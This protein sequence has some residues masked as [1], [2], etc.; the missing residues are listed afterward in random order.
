VGPAP[1]AAS[2]VRA[3]GCAAAPQGLHPGSAASPKPG[4]CRNAAG[5]WPGPAG[6]QLLLGPRSGLGPGGSGAV[7]RSRAMW[8]A[9]GPGACRWPTN[10]MRRQ[11]STGVR[12][13]SRNT[14][15]SCAPPRT[16][17]GLDP[18]HACLRHT[19][20]SC[21][22]GRAIQQSWTRAGAWLACMMER[23][24]RARCIPTQ[25][26]QQALGPGSAC[27]LHRPVP[28]A[29]RTEPG[30]A[31]R[32]CRRTSPS[33]SNAWIG[34]TACAKRASAGVHASSANVTCGA[35]L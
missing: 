14:C 21:A 20:S 7:M 26:A 6:R 8:C 25:S 2:G 15:C 11:R 34:A 27:P 4:A 19:A 31:R 1:A 30:A 5:S 10:V 28:A 3:G 12:S 16:C 32:A 22:P 24:R 17:R 9:P 13:P 29:Q 35:R 23:R 33:A 18:C